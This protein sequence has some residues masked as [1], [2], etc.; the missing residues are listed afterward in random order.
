MAMFDLS[1]ADLLDYRP[2]VA[3][4]ADFDAFWLRT[5][6]AARQHESAA[7][8]TPYDALLPGVRVTDVRFSGYDGQPVAAW[9]VEPAGAEG[10]R[11]CVV[12]F[13]GYGGGRGRPHEWLLWPAAG[14][15]VL[16]VDS[17]GQ[18]DGDTPDLAG[19]TT[20]HHSGLMT[21]GVLD[22]ELYYYRR[23]FTDAVRAVDLAATLPG[24]DPARVVVAG[25][26][27]GG[28]IAQAVAGL[29]PGVAAALIDVPFLTHFR[30][31][32]EITDSYPYQ[33]LSVFCA[34]NRDRVEQVFDTLSYFDGVNFAARATAPALYSVGLMDD[35][36]PPSTVYAAYNR[37]GGPKT[38]QVWSYNRHEGGGSFQSPVQL[39]WLREL[40]G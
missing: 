4:P 36:C 29:H 7:E 28:G 11:P 5:L 23:L 12:Q 32:S 10:P 18:G 21:R 1:P 40:F 16:V 31:A 20:P 13:I 37:Y 30:R 19:D 25:A 39:R 2:E 17:R 3:E 8:L 27:Q 9:L 24:V 33:E 34:T 35:V 26:S 6:T 15:A 38:M 14:Y 22:P